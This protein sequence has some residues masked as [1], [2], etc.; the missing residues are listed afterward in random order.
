MKTPKFLR[1]SYIAVTIT[2]IVVIM[3]LPFTMVSQK[4]MYQTS[5]KPITNSDDN[6]DNDKT[7]SPYFYVQSENPDVDQLPLKSTKADVTI[8]GVIA[9]VKVTQVYVNN[10]K[11]T[12]EAIYVFPAS[13]RAAVYDMR[14]TLGD[15]LLIAKIQEKA[16][17]REQYEAAKSEGKTASLLEQD[18]PNVFQ[19]NVANIMPGDTINV[20]MHYTELLIPEGGVYEFVY[21]TIV[22]PRYSNKSEATAAADDKWVSN[23][24]TKEGVDPTYAFDIKAKIN[25]GMKI[26]AISCPSHQVS[27]DYTESNSAIIKLKKSETDEG[28]RDF[29]LQYKLADNAIESGLLLYKGATDEENFFLTMIQP[30][31]TPEIDMV[32]PREF[33]FIMDVSGSMYGFPVETEKKLLKNLIS[34]LRP[35][36]KF[37]VL[38][39][40]GSSTTLSDNSMPAT[41]ANLKKAITM[42]EKQSGGGGTEI[43]P[44]LQKALALNKSEGFS[45]T[46]VISTD[47]YVDVEK[48]TF[49]L[50]KKNLGNSNFFAF[51]VGTAVNRYIIEGMANVGLGESFVVTDEK[52]CDKKAEKFRK[53]IQTPVLTNIT[54]DY[55]D[56]NVYDI[57][58][59]NIPDVLAERPIIIY[60]KWKGDPKGT[61]T[62]KGKTGQKDF[63]WTADVSAANLSTDNVAIK[64]LWAR[65]KIKMLD[66]YNNIGSDTKLQEEITSLG[67]KY[68][69]LTNYT[70]FIAIDSLVRNTT[71]KSTTV[72]QPL[73]LP[74]KVSDYAVGEAKGVSAIG[75]TGYKKCEKANFS[76]SQ[77]YSSNN[78]VVD[79]EQIADTVVVYLTAQY[80]AGETALQNFIKK[81]L[82]YPEKAKTAGISGTVKIQFTIDAKGNLSDFKV[83]SSLGYGCD[84]EAIRLIK[85]TAGLWTP[86]EQGGVAISSTY[87]LP[88]K[89]LLK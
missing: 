58:P 83:I 35:I 63:S 80:S 85:L 69:L 61:I 3:I 87:T 23:P 66:D 12:L 19:M 21:P 42:I 5:L 24:Y 26:K 2:A 18:R 89:F 88:V 6:D 11:N 44:A 47:G 55:G 72:K 30:P 68:N 53:Y 49:D 15:R 33:I 52:D 54:A 43:L 74:D 81:N 57:E 25:A 59:L 32:P 82:T 62:I 28:N 65:Q 40:A 34:K 29:I 64:Y 22:G 50:I 1:E 39:F 84:E 10:G 48:E 60:G 27:V 13:T 9:D 45:R 51:G 79:E 86:A 70:S 75:S 37:N 36:D 14:M 41:D 77:S 17:A 38:L 4:P 20:E 71:G 16:K 31:A 8:A 56:F 76:Y 46:F 73:P 78:S 7:L 67:L